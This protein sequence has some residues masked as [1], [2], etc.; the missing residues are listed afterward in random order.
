MH[1]KPVDEIEIIQAVEISSL[2]GNWREQGG[3]G[4]GGGR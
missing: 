2:K 4:G 1:E 3:G